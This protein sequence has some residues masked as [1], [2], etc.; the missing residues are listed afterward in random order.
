MSMKKFNLDK[1]ELI[2]LY[3]TEKKSKYKIGKIYG[4]SFKTILNRMREY[5]MKSLSRSIIQNR[6]DKKSFSND[7]TEKAYLIG[8]RLGDL[9]VYKRTENSEFIVARCHTTC[10]PQVQLMRRLF[11]RYGQVS[12]LKSIKANSYHINCYLDGSFD[13]LLSKNV[14]VAD[15][16]KKSNK[17]AAAFAAGYIDAE[18]NAGVYDG[19]ARLKIDSYDKG[20]IFWLHEWFLKNKIICPDPI[21]IGKNKQIYNKR[22]GYKYNNDLWRIRVSE[23]ASLLKLFK[24]VYGQLRHSKRKG[25]FRECLKNINDRNNTK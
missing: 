11:K 12:V 14:E 3:Y 22:K 10:V 18:G 5:G 13:F 6:Y 21:K 23:K 25:D 20:I 7:K 19:R 16:V 1:K 15:W 17:Y 4:C 9:N 8:F 2:R 24:L